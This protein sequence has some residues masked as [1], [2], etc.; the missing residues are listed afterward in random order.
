MILKHN[1]SKLL[2]FLLCSAII[3]LFVFLSGVILTPYI[4]LSEDLHQYVTDDINNDVSVEE[5]NNVAISDD[6]ALIY[7]FLAV[8]VDEASGL[9]DVIL[10]ASFNLKTQK[11]VVLQIPRDTY[12]NVS[13][14]DYK[15]I[16]GAIYELGS[17]DGF[18]RELEAAW[19]IK[20]DYTI[21]FTLNTFGKLVDSIGGVT[22]NI[23]NNM[24]YDDPYQNLHI[25]L[26]EGE[27]LLDGEMA[28]QFVRFRSGYIRG[29]L[30]RTDA[31]KIIMS[32]LVE[33]FST[34]ISIFQLSSLVDLLLE[35]VETNMKLSDCIELSKLLLS[36]NPKNVIMLTLCGLDARTKIDSGAWYYII[37]RSATIEIL[38]RY[39]VADCFKNVENNFDVK[40]QFSNEKYPHFEKIY[41][42]DG[43]EIFEYSA[44]DINN[45]GIEIGR[46]N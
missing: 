24:D 28:K 33:K 30:D 44:E 41:Y 11:L 4:P 18:A 26:E 5:D 19:N 43:Y 7:N 42:D 29:D 37:N 8:G 9:T 46:I 40:K 38:N 15:K 39:F 32:A 22:V 16:N 21:K 35:D 6:N 31:Q 3:L 10:L 20:I 13:D 2:L 12:F 17:V 23:P 25:H 27:H 1:W 36:V 34:D 45:E 14:S